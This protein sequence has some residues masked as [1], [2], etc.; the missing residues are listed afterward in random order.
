MPKKHT[1]SIEYGLFFAG[2]AFF[3]GVGFQY[4]FM[5]KEPE[6]SSV[7]KKFSPNETTIL[8]SESSKER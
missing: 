3:I 5:H 1:S 8:M 4:V 6:P 2:L 7:A